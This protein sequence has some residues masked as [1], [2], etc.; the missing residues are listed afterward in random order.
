MLMVIIL[1]AIWHFWGKVCWNIAMHRTLSLLIA[2][3]ALLVSAAHLSALKRKDRRVSRLT[4]PFLVPCVYGAAFTFLGFRLP[5]A[6]LAASAAVCYTLGDILLDRKGTIPFILGSLSFILG[7]LCLS[8]RSA[9]LSPS[10]WLIAGAA[11][12]AIPYALFLLKLRG[13]EGYWQYIAY[14]GAV[15]ILLASSFAAFPGLS[16]ILAVIGAAF[17]GY[18][19]SMIMFRMAKIKKTPDHIVMGTYILANVFLALSLI[20]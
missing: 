15:Y 4:K 17:Y 7:H 13:K 19:D 8:T 12:A 10:P 20:A 6:A 3:L 11:A 1:R 5:L 9:L 18:S 14:G 16:S 2:L